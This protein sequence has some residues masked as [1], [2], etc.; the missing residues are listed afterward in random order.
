M[1]GRHL[2]ATT[3]LLI[4]GFLAGGL[5]AP[6]SAYVPVAQN[7]AYEIPLR[8]FDLHGYQSPATLAGKESVAAQLG[9][10]YGGRWQVESWNPQTHTPRNIY[11]EGPQVAPALTSDSDVRQAAWQVVRNNS[12]LLGVEPGNLELVDVTRG[13]GK[14]AAHFQQK[15]QGLDVWGGR[16]HVTFT[17]GGKLMVMSS[18][19]YGNLQV[20]VHPSIPAS[21]AADIARR[22]VPF[23]SRTDSIE[24]DPELLVLPA[25]I[26]VTEVEPL[27]VW[28]IRVHTADPLG[29]WVTH[30]DAHTGE[31]VWRYN[32]VRFVDFV[33]DAESDIRPGTYCNP[34]SIEASAHLD[35]TV[36]G[37]GNTTTDADGNWT[38]A[39]G[40]TDPHT[41][42]SELA[43][44][45]VDINNVAGAQASFSG[46]ATPGVGFT[47]DW[48]S[49]NS[50]ADEREVF[51]AINDI[52]EFF[53]LFAPDFS[54]IN[55]QIAA[56]VSINST[57]NAFWNGSI[58]FY[59]EGS[60][61][62]NTGE[63]QGVAQHEYGHGVQQTL[64]GGTTAQGMHE[65]NAD[66]LANFMTDESAIGRGFYL[67]QCS[68][69][70][71]NSENSLQ[72]PGD[73]H[74]EPHFDGQI[75]A[76]V[77]WDM[78]QELEN[79]LGSE[80]GKLKAAEL[81]HYG[82]GLERPTNQPDQ[83][84]SYFVADD[85]DGD[86]TNG[87]PHHAAICVAAN[88]HGF[89][90]PEILVGVLISHVPY[91]APL[92]EGDVDLSADIVS[93]FA[94][95]DPNT[96]KVVYKRNNGA[97]I[98]LPMSQ[99][100]L[101]PESFTAT[102]AD[103]TEPSKVDYY[104]TAEDEDGNVGLDPADA[105]N[106][107]FSFDIPT[108]FD[109]IETENGW[110]VDLEGTDD[111]TTGV[112]ERVDPVG[113]LAQPEDDHTVD[114]GHLCWVTGQQPP[115][116][117]LGTND[118][119]GGSTTL[120]SPVYDLTG[121]GFAVVKYWRW[122]SNGTG[123]DPYNDNWVVQARNNGGPWV[124]VENTMDNQVQWY[125]VESDLLALFSGD[126]I[127]EVQFK[128]IASDLSQGSV[129]EAA[130]DDFLLHFT[131]TSVDVPPDAMA[132]AR[133]ALYGSR[134]NPVRGLG[135]VSFQVPSKT[136]VD[137][138]I[139]DVAGRALRTLVNGSVDA[140]LH[141]VSWDGTD[142]QGH[143]LAS[144]VYYARMDAGDFQAT[145]SV[146]ISR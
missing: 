135:Q 86:L 129:V 109:D 3:V 7:P 88:N 24:G 72:Y 74:G 127:G 100:I 80:S 8:S 91:E 89:D 125:Q 111:A 101:D 37:V 48:N 112:W 84:F 82:R 56:N 119:D 40:G 87:T 6:A 93:T 77:T 51:D 30:V 34:D 122:Y 26:S 134:P 117:D 33:G 68:S 104:I 12:H 69:G 78:R 107:L 108:L 115:G 71:R 73:L 136:R 19:F 47:I 105:P 23:D 132:T 116:G 18:D 123:A 14:S 70:I 36:S 106:T 103:L 65:G 44:P 81:W 144:G 41:V 146:V 94:P 85:D 120:Y 76:G 57:C 92:P 113:T 21:V 27:L 38:V 131:G 46:T 124:T 39:Y 128:F 2:G 142:D 102:I 20:D 10:R 95:I 60:G 11:G 15:Y 90:C 50:Q 17:D 25:P 5:A 35:L 121:S 141:S 42:T 32:D 130:L 98:N 64:V 137:L 55:Q 29:I 83:V 54:Y 43:G 28:R 1:R 59:R 13:L 61:C 145:R 45:Y 31:I 96:V 138:T 97:F 4:A 53:L 118:V 66:I 114:P 133:F 49:S 62:A 16:A 52:H 99:S 63:I 67:G 110:T 79:D 140:G 75:I 126:T 143:A 22:G 139:Y 58:N 9:Q